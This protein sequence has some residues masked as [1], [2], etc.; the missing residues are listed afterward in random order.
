MLLA[1]TLRSSTLRFALIAIGAF[2]TVMFALIGYLYWSTL[3]YAWTSAHREIAA[4]QRVLD[5]AFET[6]GRAGLVAAIAER[7]AG[8]D[9]AAVYALA[10]ENLVPIA[11]NLGV[12]PAALVQGSGWAVIPV[13]RSE[14]H[15]RSFQV[16]FE[17]LADGSHL[18]TGRAIDD[19]DG[20]GRSI[21][22]AIAGVSAFLIVLAGV[23][24]LAVTRRTVGRI[25]AINATSRAI[26][27]RGPGQRIPL[28]GTK[29]EWDHLAHNLNLAL[30]RIEELMREIKQV[31]DNVAHD[32]RTPLTRMRARL[33]KALERGRDVTR[34]QTLIADTIAELDTVLGMFSSLLRISQIEGDRRKGGF[35]TVYLADVVNEVV[36]LFDAAA[37]D[38]GGRIEVRTFGRSPV[39]GDRDLLFDAVANIVDNAI[40]HGGPAGSVSVEVVERVGAAMIAV[41]D[42]GPG[43]PAQHRADVFK[44]FYRLDRSRC[45]SGNGLGLSLVAAV[46]NL[47]GGRIELLD[48][49]PGLLVQLSFPTHA[50]APGA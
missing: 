35:R 4:E 50:A 3:T 7:T 8:Q 10:D 46:V 2:G 28:R 37:E 47:H 44:R 43:I 13:D 12:W 38:V 6:M 23:A 17:T 31:S 21:R 5:H 42:R 20:F 45:S 29:D 48:N 16:G 40:K 9:R 34:D 19:L 41:G 1:E 33:E 49:N 14:A 30:E 27:Q 39:T 32:L 36:E 22:L 11:G 15:R 26:L 25:A 24:S 18:L